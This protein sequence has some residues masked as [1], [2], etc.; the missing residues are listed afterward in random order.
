MERKKVF[1]WSFLFSVMV[2]SGAYAVTHLMPVHT[3]VAARTDPPIYLDQGWSKADRDTYYWIPQ[4][5]V[6]MSYD[7]LT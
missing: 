1:L 4:G 2:L 5:T 3:A 7:I 6:M